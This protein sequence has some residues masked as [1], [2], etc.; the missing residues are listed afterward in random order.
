VAKSIADCTVLLLTVPP[1]PAICKTLSKCMSIMFQDSW[2]NR[3]RVQLPPRQLTN[4]PTELTM[5]WP[6]R[7]LPKSIFGACSAH[8]VC[9]HYWDDA[10]RPSEHCTARTSR[11]YWVSTHAA[12]VAD[13]VNMFTGLLDCLMMMMSCWCQLLDQRTDCTDIAIP[14]RLHPALS[15]SLSL[16]LSMP[17]C[18]L[19]ACVCVCKYHQHHRHHYRNAIFTNC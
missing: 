12:S 15:L 10:D 14:A 4:W 1:C 16:S 5:R 2:H 7:G 9:Q 6:I 19:Y 17:L 18:V 13:V 8:G 11:T 3:C